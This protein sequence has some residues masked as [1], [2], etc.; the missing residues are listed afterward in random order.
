M[1]VAHL[2]VMAHRRR[3][4]TAI[5]RWDP[6]GKGSIPSVRKW[7]RD[8]GHLKMSVVTEGSDAGFRTWWVE[9]RDPIGR[10]IEGVLCDAAFLGL[11]SA[12]V[13]PIRSSPLARQ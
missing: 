7:K 12:G 2:C 3:S 1:S 6:H 10:R 13:T 5:C 11:H 8:P 9:R 4:L